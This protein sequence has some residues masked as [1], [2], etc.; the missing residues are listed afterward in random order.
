VKIRT[1]PDIIEREAFESLPSILLRIVDH[2]RDSEGDRVIFNATAGFGVVLIV[3]GMLAMRYGFRVYYQNERMT[4][5]VVIQNLHV[6]WDAPW[7]L[8]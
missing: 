2:H 8:S 3:I 1:I 5:P 7:I 6:S 4:S